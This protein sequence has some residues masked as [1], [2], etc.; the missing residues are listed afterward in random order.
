MNP[1]FSIVL[2]KKDE[3]LLR[4]I[5]RFFGNVGSFKVK[6]NIVQ[7]RVF[8]IEELCVII[9]HFDNFPLVTKKHIDFLLF[10]EAVTLIKNKEHLTLEGFNKI[11]SLRASMNLGLPESLKDFSNIKEKIIA[12]KDLPDVLDPN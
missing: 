12:P 9:D 10:K 3:W 4:E 1:A 6:E 2:H 11:I 5:Q 8:S 7:F